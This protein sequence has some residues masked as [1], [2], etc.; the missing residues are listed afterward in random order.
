[1]NIL[2]NIHILEEVNMPVMTVLRE[3]TKATRIKK[4]IFQVQLRWKDYDKGEHSQTTFKYFLSDWWTIM[5]SLKWILLFLLVNVLFWHSR[6][7]YREKWSH[8][9]YEDYYLA[10][11]KTW[12]HPN[13][14]QLFKRVSA[15]LAFTTSSNPWYLSLVRTSEAWKHFR[16]M[17]GNKLC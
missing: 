17:S 9:M 5:K 2:G 1:M 8:K 13:L 16:R 14:R 6:S 11:C 7:V 10:F 15:T 12:L 3:Q 4:N